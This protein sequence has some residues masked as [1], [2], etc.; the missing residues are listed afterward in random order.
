VRLEDTAP[1]A[2]TTARLAAEA[3]AA[4]TVEAVVH[5]VVAAATPEA[6]MDTA[7]MYRASS[8]APRPDS[9]GTAAHGDNALKRN[10]VSRRVL[11][12]REAKHMSSMRV[13]AWFTWFTA[14]NW[15]VQTATMS[16][17]RFAKGVIRP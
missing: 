7:R 17:E 12:E 9:S 14:W 1:R 3:V 11:Y 8:E 15:L 6:G 5:T 2:A 16:R 4:I 13:A 10:S